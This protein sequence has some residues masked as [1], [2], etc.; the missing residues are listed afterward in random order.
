MIISKTIII[1]K[2]TGKYCNYYKQLGYDIKSKYIE[3]DIKDLS[4]GSKY[5]IEAQCQ[6]CKIIKKIDYNSYNKS[7]KNNKILYSCKK[8]GSLKHKELFLEKWG[9]E[10]PFQ[11]NSIKE[12]IKE[13]NIEK[14]GVDSYTKTNEFRENFIKTNLGKWGVE[15]PS[16]SEDIKEKKR[17]TFIKNWGVD[18]Y[19]KTNEYIER[20][21][22][23]SLEKW[24]VDSYTKTNEFREK[25]IKTNLEKY[26]KEYHTMTDEWKDKI[27]SINIEKYGSSPFENETFRKKNYKIANNES[28]I[29]YMGNSISLFKC[30]YDKDHEFEISFD[31][32]KSRLNNNIKLCTVCNPIGDSQSIKEKELYHYIKSIYSDEIIQSWRNG[33]EIDIYLPHLKIGFEFNGLYWHSSDKKD[34][35]YHINKTNSFKELGIRII[36]IWEDDWNFKRDI[37]K[38]QIKNWLGITENKVFARKCYVKEIKDSKTATKFLE[39]NHIQGK[40]NSNIKLGLYYNEELVSL[41]TFDHFEGRKKMSDDGWNLSRFCNKLNTN[42]I[43]G[44][45]K[46][47]KYFINIYKPKRIISYA[48][49]DWSM[50]G[51]YYKIGFNKLYETNPDYKYII[52]NKRINKSRFRR[53]KGDIKTETQKM[54]ERKIYKI[55]DCGKI[56]YSYQIKL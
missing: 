52:D 5:K 51:V 42:V 34:K 14:W 4:L 24:G 35:W 27:K 21:K 25:V 54:H 56:K 30:D 41:M 45:S 6:Y 20:S 28:Y 9:V 23:T 33:L 8:C 43:G 48:D 36:H 32:Y 10:N 18:S 40:V 31:N 49:K 13:T 16:Q 44:A 46:L 38:S 37:I 11:S 39:K 3:I 12:K 55:W 15:N 47:L 53:D 2:P 29:K 22:K 17:K 50:G 7:T 1:N 19:T 26:G